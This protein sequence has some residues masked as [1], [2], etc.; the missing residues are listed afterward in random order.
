M[1]LI[2]Q[3]GNTHI[4]GSGDSLEAEVINSWQATYTARILLNRLNKTTVVYES[5]QPEKDVDVE[6]AK[7]KLKDLIQMIS[8]LLVKEGI[9]TLLKDLDPAFPWREE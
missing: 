7:K 8:V 9:A 2:D 4:L 1:I 5:L 3:K 6:R